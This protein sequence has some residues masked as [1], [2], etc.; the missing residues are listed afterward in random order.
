MDLD[1][2]TP[3]PLTI[4]C[5]ISSRTSTT[6][7]NNAFGKAQNVSLTRSSNFVEVW[8]GFQYCYLE[9]DTTE[10]DPTLTQ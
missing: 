9:E 5:T 8:P 6:S 2:T 7:C 10:L 1:V 3:V 4:A